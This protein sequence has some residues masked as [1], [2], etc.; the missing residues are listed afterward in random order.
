MWGATR[1]PRCLMGP[2]V[3]MEPGICWEC[4]VTKL[5]GVGKALGRKVGRDGRIPQVRSSVEYC[6]QALYRDLCPGKGSSRCSL[7]LRA[8]VQ[9]E[10]LEGVWT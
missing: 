7:T 6:C 8:A 9:W 1:V 5:E 4:F 3:C 2:A 10:K